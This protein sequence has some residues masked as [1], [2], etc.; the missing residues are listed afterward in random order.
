ML[1]DHTLFLGNKLPS[2]SWSLLFWLYFFLA[3]DFTKVTA[4]TLTGPPTGYRPDILIKSTSAAHYITRSKKN[5]HS[6]ESRIIS[7]KE[8]ASQANTH[9][10]HYG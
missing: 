3:W 4:Q 1:L 8:T 10:M 9:D 5:N 6:Q 7:G 2:F